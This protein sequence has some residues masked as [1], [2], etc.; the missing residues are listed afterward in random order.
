VIAFTRRFIRLLLIPLAL[1][2]SACATRQGPAAAPVAP[3][4]AAPSTA[5]TARTIPRT[6]DGKP[7][8]QGIWQVRNRA[9]YGL[10]YHA[11]SLGILPGRSVLVGDTTIPYTP[12]ALK[13]RNE[14][15]EKR[16]ELDPF[17]NCFMPGVPRMMYI[18]HPFQIFQTPTHVAMTF[19]WSQ[20]FRL[21]YTDGSKH[22][23]SIEFW[24]GDSRGHWEGD[25]FVAEVTNHNDRTW[26][27]ASG[28]FHSEQLKLI[29]RYTMVDPDTIQYEVTF[30]DPKVYTKP[31]KISM[32]FFRHKD[33]DR[34]LE[35]QCQAEKEEQNG[36]FER[37]ERT[38][39]PKPKP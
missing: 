14:N 33:M 17:N 32:P 25:T 24:M 9:A 1:V 22:Q 20:V 37:D 7:N 19:E 38:W 39:Y 3:A 27:D 28:N 2:A 16:A 8:L 12:A 6:A 31:W 30:E 13:Q 29:E 11:A 4:A 21:I 36:D 34:L 5:T 15:F 26:L 10:E 23:D 35:Y 18:E